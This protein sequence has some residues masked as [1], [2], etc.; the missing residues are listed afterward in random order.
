MAKELA[1][2]AG[3]KKTI[4]A[5]EILKAANDLLQKR[6]RCAKLRAFVFREY[7]EGLSQ[8]FHAAL[9][10]FPHKADAF[11]SWFDTHAAA[12][13]RSVA[14]DQAGTL[15][16]GND[17]GHRWRTNLLG[18]SE[19]TERLWAAENEDGQGGKLGG[20]DAA[21]A[22]ADAQPAQKVDGGGVKVIGDFGRCYARRGYRGVEGERRRGR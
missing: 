12:V 19:F 2:V 21:F 11:W 10:A 14:A 5:Y 13:F 9:A 20:T 3:F 6:Y 7:G 22:I 15:K 8:G 16:T 18:G 4:K 17:S 1:V